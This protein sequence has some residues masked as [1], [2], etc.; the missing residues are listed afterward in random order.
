MNW[1]FATTPTD[2]MTFAGVIAIFVSVGM[3]ACLGPAWRATTVDPMRALRT[4]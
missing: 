2:P 1:L 3:L 4:D